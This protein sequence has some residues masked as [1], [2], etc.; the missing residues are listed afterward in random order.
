MNA[1]AAMKDFRRKLISRR[2]MYRTVFDTDP[3]HK[4]LKDLRKFCKVGQDVF[5]PGDPH[6]TS[7]NSGLQ[8]VYLRI[9]SIMKMDE[10]VINEI[11]R[12]T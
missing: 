11:S 6:A 4:V 12:E 10:D 1:V 9:E 3:G 2:T 5:V 8:R 7:Y